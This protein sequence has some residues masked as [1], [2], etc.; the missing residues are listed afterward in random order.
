M[1]LWGI[2]RF[3]LAYQLR[4][5]WPWLSMA[6]LTVFAFLNT[7]VGIVPV[8]LPQDFVLNS[9][10]I[11]AAV[12]VFSCQIWLLL[13]PAVTGEAA[14]RDVHTGMYPLTY[15][16]PVSKAE[17]LGGRFLAAF[18]L[19]VLILLGVQVGSL[20][21][22]YAPGV[23]PE[24]IG[25]FR[26][27]AYLAAYVFI[28]LTNAFIATTFQ[29]SVALWSGRPIAS[30]VGS[31]GLFFL[32]YPVT[33]TL[34]L[35]GL[36]ERALLA[37]PIGVLAIMN[38]MMSKW[39]LAEKNVRMFTLEGPMLWNR[40]LWLGIS[41]VMSAFLYLRYRFAHRTETGFWSRLKRRFARTA[42]TPETAPARIAISVP[43][44][45]QSFGFATHWRQTLAIARSSF[46]MI[47]KNPAGVFLL[48]V[49]PM[50]LVLVQTVQSERWGVPLLPRT[51]Y[52]LTR[53]LTSPLTEAVDFRVIIPLL[54]VYFAGEL[55]WRERDARLSE[56]VDATPAP[57]WV[58]FGGKLLGLSLVL[59]ALMV[60]LAV[61]GMIVQAMAGYHDFQIGLYL[62]VLFGLQLPEY[63]L[64]AALA[65]TVHVVV[66]QKYAG[67]LVSLV[68]YFLIIFS[69]FLGIEHN[70]LIYAASPAWSFT[71]MRGFSGSVGPW[72]WF[73]LYW[74]AWALLLAVV[75]RLLW[76][77]GRES[78][79]G[80]RL[81][82]A[83]LRFNRAT[84]AVAAMTFGL[85][86][87]LGG[88]IFYN[89]NM[90]NEYI[91]EDE[92]VE[93][94]ADY[95]RRYGKYE[96]IPQPQRTATKLQIEI[97]PGR[98]AATVRGSYRLVNR[99]AV[100]IGSVHLEPAFHVETRVTFDR[101]AR[102]VEADEKLGHFI[103]V[104]NEP[105]QPGDSLT[106]DFDVQLARRGFRNSGLRSNGAGPAVLENGTYLTGSALPVIGYQPLRELW[107]AEDRRRHGL[108]RQITLP[109]PDDIDPNVVAGAPATFDAIVG[110]DA[111]QVAVAPGELR[112]TW[113]EG[114]RRYFHYVSDVPIG[115]LYLFF[116]A[117]YAVHRE[118]WK[119]VDLQVFVH[120]GHREHLERLLRGVRASLDYYSAQFGPYPYRFLQIVEQPGNFLG[121]GVDGSGVVTGGEGFFLLNPEG[122]GF[123][124][125][126]EIVAH[127]M[128][129]QWW[130]TQ[131]KP[132]FAE[133]GGVLS[134]GLAWYSAMQ[135]V[136]HEKDRE[137]LRRFMSF[138]REP[139]PWPPIRTGLPLLR[140]MDPW[141]NYRKGPYA[142]YALSEYVGEA[143][144]NGALRT[145]VEKKASSLATT[146]DLYRE[147]QAVTPGSLQ[148]L[149]ADLFE[150]NTFWRFE[151]Q[152][153][154]AV[155]TSAGNWQV[156]MEVEAH[157]VVADSAGKETEVPIEEG[158][159]IG[160]FAPARPGELLGQPLHVQ[161]HRVRSGTQTITI[162]VPEKPAR[163]GID[164]YSLLDWEEGDNIERIEIEEAPGE[165]QP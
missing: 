38:E 155:Q 6:V 99:D 63:L 4:R 24:I 118:R 146:L 124:A 159:E 29:F 82:I 123:D 101:P 95:E 108:P 30:Y 70:L 103:Y 19:H 160:V 79:F 87:A 39:T 14:A 36:G 141:A 114:G 56:N 147:L 28:G 49:F 88:F 55:I 140:A 119:D 126:F 161:K 93:R 15:T 73:K 148:P 35:S 62:E 120:P 97:H 156:T 77:R 58:L 136:K 50:F 153:A 72:L 144:V 94:R 122:D 44:V 31:L 111:D 129:H 34:Y 142:M 116:S 52:L 130:G 65:L 132:A 131:L 143:R 158:I 13:A 80:T 11:I 51:G 20:L 157:K 41:L 10:F 60:M 59:A 109:P 66:N 64:F 113:T 92:Q 32:S 163:G 107:S 48:V 85:L 25:P 23:S 40:L 53:Y 7:R 165:S 1:K 16:S 22:A 68:L 47:A 27:A 90:R 81:K 33:F 75:A 149:L 139:N 12:S 110:T 105:L 89:T 154:T 26:P 42:P 162:V 133:G 21:A 69:P 17:Y 37:D 98:R 106:L 164:P 150:R 46:W 18:V 57:E 138:M 134:E 137:A 54:L 125:I 86:L 84:A 74:G 76:V 43:Q 121:M 135:L 78:G 8:T 117:D 100:P 83:R 96:G 128:G 3:E 5:P 115:G 145:L 45:R 127:E 61:S 152:Q 151:T 112:R 102:L 71:D 2:F 67:L 9:P 91:S 104:L